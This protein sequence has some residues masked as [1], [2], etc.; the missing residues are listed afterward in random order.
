MISWLPLVSAAKAILV[1]S[2]YYFITSLSRHH[3]EATLAKTVYV[4]YSLVTGLIWLLT[5]LTA[6]WE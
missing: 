2:A 4:R 6:R 3:I 1:T 5:L